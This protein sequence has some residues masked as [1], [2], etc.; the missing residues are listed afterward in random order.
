MYL[1]K[2]NDKRSSYSFRH[3]YAEQRLQEIGTNPQALDYIAA[4]MG[5][6]WQMLQNFYIRKGQNVD[7]DTLIGFD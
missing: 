3:Y 1:D 6:S 2:N 7:L 5:T 4:N